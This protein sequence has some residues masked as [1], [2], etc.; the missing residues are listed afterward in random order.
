MGSFNPFQ[1]ILEIFSY[2]Y[3]FP[4]STWCTKMKMDNP[5][6]G[7]MHENGCDGFKICL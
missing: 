2:V 3:T 6:I 4:L 7:Q 1:C 5:F